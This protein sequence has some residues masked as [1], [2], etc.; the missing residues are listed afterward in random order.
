MY[1]LYILT[2]LFSM[3]YFRLKGSKKAKK[4]NRVENII[5]AFFLAHPSLGYL[6]PQRPAWAKKQGLFISGR[7]AWKEVAVREGGTIREVMRLA[8]LP[9]GHAES[10]SFVVDSLFQPDPP[11]YPS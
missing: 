7:A 4:E 6:L 10:W 5:I 3:V 2:T 8:C 11:T 1:E 9:R